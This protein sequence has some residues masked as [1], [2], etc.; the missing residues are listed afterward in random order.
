MDTP[1]PLGLPAAT[2]GYSALY[3][4]TLVLHVVF[5]NYVLA[6]SAYLAFASLFPG[7]RSVPRSHT[8]TAL[9]LRDWMPF[10]L[11]AAITAGVA[12]LLFIQILYQRPFYTANLLL[13]H[14]WMA[15]LPAL[16]VGFYLLYLLKSRWVAGWPTAPRVLVGVGAF[17][18]FA[19][20]GISWVENHL[21]S[22]HEAT[23]PDFYA[24]G[25]IHYRNI[26]L[27]PRFLLWLF[28]SFPTMC[29]LVA[30]QLRHLQHSGQPL[31]GNE[32]RRVARLAL[33]GLALA[34]GC[35]IWY[36]AWMDPTGR[37]GVAGPAAAPYLALAAIGMALQAMAWIGLLRSG[38]FARMWLWLAF[39]GL[40][41]SLIGTSVVREVMRW[42]AVDLDTLT[43]QHEQAAQVG[44]LPA[45]LAFL[46]LNVFLIAWC[47]RIGLRRQA[48]PS[49]E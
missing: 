28:G 35:A 13:F 4:V 9:V 18:C 40:L 3:I 5:M 46:V 16:I 44:G 34:A 30:W 47:C 23:W 20:T 42:T 15:I 33:I 21:L 6:G 31:P 38:T 10:A 8:P 26:Q 11:S 19:F 1:W 41:G 27:I 29:L 49:T 39:A 36:Y 24:S 43:A 14:R 32:V 25:A 45:F 7:R 22:L 48:S 2:S 37:D 17:L 12:P